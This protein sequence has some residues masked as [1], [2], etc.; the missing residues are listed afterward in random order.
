[1]EIWSQTGQ[2]F[3]V[4]RVFVVVVAEMVLIVKLV[5]VQYLV[6][7]VVHCTTFGCTYRVG[8]CTGACSKTGARCKVFAY[9]CRAKLVVVDSMSKSVSYF[10]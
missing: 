1:M 5:L 8:A 10:V 7:L 2:V 9:T 3:V 6:L 4:G